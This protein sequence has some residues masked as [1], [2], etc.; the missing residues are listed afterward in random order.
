MNP[1]APGQPA[2]VGVKGVMESWN[3]T[4]EKATGWINGHQKALLTLTQQLGEGT[5]IANGGAN[6]FASGFISH[7]R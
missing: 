4:K 6:K 7:K 1:A 2:S 3:V 5:L